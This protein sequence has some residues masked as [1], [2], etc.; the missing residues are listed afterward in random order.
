[1]R[2]TAVVV[3]L[4]TVFAA[5]GSDEVNDVRSLPACELFQDVADDVAA[6]VLTAPEL[7]E[8]LKEIDGDARVAPDDVK[9]A[10]EAMLRASTQGDSAALITAGSQMTA[11]CAPEG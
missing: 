6:G 1:M 4:L 7:R 11:A 5:C 2:R 3:L 9:T 8:K 10:A